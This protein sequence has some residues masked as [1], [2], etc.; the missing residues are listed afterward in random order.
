MLQHRFID[1]LF[2]PALQQF[3][4]LHARTDDFVTTVAKAR[5][6]KIVTGAPMDIV[7]ADILSGL[8]V[9][10]DGLRYILVLTDYFYKWA[11]TFV[12][13]DAETST[14]MRI[15]YDG[16]FTQYGLPNQLHTDQGRNFESKL[17]YEMCQLTGV[18][19]TRMTPFHPQSDRQTE[20]MNRTLLQMLR[21]TADENPESWPHRL[22]SVMA[23][24]RMTVHRLTGVSPNMVM[25][26]R[27]VLL[28]ASLIAR[29]PVEPV[30]TTVPFVNDLRDVMRDANERIRQATKKEARTQRKYYDNRSCMTRFHEGQKVWLY[31]PRPP[32]RQQFT[33]LTRLW[34]SPWKIVL[35]KSPVVVELHHVSNG[36]IQVVHVDCLLPCVPLPA[37]S[38]ETDD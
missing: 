14:C 2:D 16:F 29:P 15:M 37:I 12:L 3:L 27:E 20:R 7:T 32:V 4:C 10:E 34:T 17:F 9:T 26:G 38:D 5:Q 35:F 31:W 33:K 11:C 21:C 28:P 23:A 22:P 6:Y 1:G 8:L 30:N 19:K 13:P 24:Y 18:V 36:A 25:L